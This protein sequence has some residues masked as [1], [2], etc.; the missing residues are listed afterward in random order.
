MAQRFPFCLNPRYCLL[1]QNLDVRSKL[2]P[3]DLPP[4]KNIPNMPFFSYICW[5]EY[6]DWV[7]LQCD[8]TLVH[9]DI[10]GQL[11]PCFLL[12]KSPP[13]LSNPPLHRVLKVRSLFWLSCVRSLSRR[14]QHPQHPQVELSISW[15]KALARP[16]LKSSLT[17]ILVSSSWSVS[18]LWEIGR[19]WVHAVSIIHVWEI[20]VYE[21]FEMGLYN[22]D[23]PF[24]SL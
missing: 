7:Y 1:L 15:A 10:S 4:G 19:R 6:L 14:P 8:S 5:L 20:E 12:R 17:S 2:F 11:L 9:M 23:V 3:Q 16:F 24:R 18:V 22:C 13:V 21:G